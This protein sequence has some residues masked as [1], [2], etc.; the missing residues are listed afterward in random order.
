M[1]HSNKR[2]FNE[3]G[4]SDVEVPINKRVV[5][6]SQQSE[7]AMPCGALTTNYSHTRIERPS[8]NNIK[9]VPDTVRVPDLNFIVLSCA[10]HGL[11][12]VTDDNRCAAKIRG[13]FKTAEEA[14]EHAQLLHKEDPY[15]DIYVAPMY[16]WI[17]FP[18]QT[19]MCEEV[20][21]T[22]KTVEEIMNRE[23]Q[24]RHASASMLEQRIQTAKDKLNAQDME[25]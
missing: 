10:A 17:V 7:V 20:H 3:D 21:V 16:E 22:N 19:G 15:F 25:S 1:D 11:A 18:P 13:A 24:H 14:D 2:F 8:L 5:Q 23:L 9:A 4:V 12:Q 6:Q